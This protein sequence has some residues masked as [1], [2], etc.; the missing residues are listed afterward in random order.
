MEKKTDIF[1]ELK[2]IAPEFSRVT[3]K[4]PFGVPENYFNDL[5]DRVF[6]NI[7]EEKPS[8]GLVDRLDRYVN[9]WFNLIFQ[10]RY[11]I[12]VASALLITIVAVNLFKG[13]RLGSDDPLNQMAEFSTEAIQNYVVE[14][15][16]SEELIAM[17]LELEQEIPEDVGYVLPIEISEE[18]INYYLDQN[19]DEQTF[20]D[21]IL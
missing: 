1:N 2:E 8:F 5:P 19:F 21:E 9:D 4:N 15:Y 11:A 17:N 3:K 18:D 20:E 13:Y 6:S 10:P 7:P 16:E 14:N 12:P